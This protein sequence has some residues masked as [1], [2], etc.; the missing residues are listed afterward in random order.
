MLSGCGIVVNPKYSGLSGW[1][2][3]LK[4]SV[5]NPVGKEDVLRCCEWEDL[6]LGEKDMKRFDISQDE[7]LERLGLEEREYLALRSGES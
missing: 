5:E 3:C 4:C 1:E 6:V 7:L 2:L